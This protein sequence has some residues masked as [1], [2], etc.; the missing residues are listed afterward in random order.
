MQCLCSW[1]R[2]LGD[3]QEHEDE[4]A[5]DAIEAEALYNILEHEVIP[6]FYTRDN[7]EIPTQ[8]VTRMRE[9]MARLTPRFSANRTV[10]EYTERYYLP[11][12]AAYRK[13][14]AERGTQGEQVRRWQRTL[15][16]HWV[17]LHLGDCHVETTNGFHVFRMPVYLGEIPPETIQVELYADAYNGEGPTRY[18]M[19][20]E[21]S[22]VGRCDEWLCV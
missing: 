4:Q 17:T 14:A 22:P 7:K 21:L 10:R 11:R 3:G 20:R 6:A 12:A 16:H 15:A 9:S 18:A 2:A 8:W 1:C 5:W 13:R 19:A